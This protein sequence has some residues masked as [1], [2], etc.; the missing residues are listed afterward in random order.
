MEIKT[1]YLLEPND[2]FEDIQEGTE[3]V[4]VR[5]CIVLSYQFQRAQ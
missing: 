3:C 4:F 1:F 5:E 2:Y